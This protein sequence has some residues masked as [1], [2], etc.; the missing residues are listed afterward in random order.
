MK[1]SLLL[2]IFMLLS[3]LAFAQYEVGDI[4]DDYSWTDDTGSAHTLYEL[5]A[6]GK[7]V[8]MFWGGTG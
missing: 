1:K 2:S 8:V 5:T 7:V 4:V 6:E 3:V